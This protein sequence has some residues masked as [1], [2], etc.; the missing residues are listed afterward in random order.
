VLAGLLVIS[1]LSGSLTAGIALA[2]P[3]PFWVV[4]LSYSVGG[5]LGIAFGVG[6]AATVMP[7]RGPD[8]RTSRTAAGSENRT[9]CSGGN[10]SST[11]VSH[12]RR[13]CAQGLRN[14]F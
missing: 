4:A 6:A 7:R 5:M 10:T 3:L 11:I 14:V 2:M 13:T 12:L 9:R 1:V 8:R